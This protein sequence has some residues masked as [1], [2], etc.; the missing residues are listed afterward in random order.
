MGI[1]K[2]EAKIKEI[3]VIDTKKPGEV[4]LKIKN[5][6]CIFRQGRKRI[7]LAAKFDPY[8]SVYDPDS[9]WIP[10]EIFKK[11]CRQA[12]QILLRK[13]VDSKKSAIKIKRP[14]QL[15]LKLTVKGGN[16]EKESGVPVVCGAS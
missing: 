1:N 14:V 4:E 9:L 10:P 16:N 5:I 13:R 12:A 2:K 8:A 3:E 15:E 7:H 11:A 6:H